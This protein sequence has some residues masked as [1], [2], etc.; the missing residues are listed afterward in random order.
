MP[1]YDFGSLAPNHRIAGPA[2]IEAETTTI[3]IGRSDILTVNA[4]G[5]L[6]IEIGRS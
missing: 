4:L 6:D 3:L 2:L 1:V 5:W